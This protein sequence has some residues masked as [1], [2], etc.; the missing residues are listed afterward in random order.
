MHAEFNSKYIIETHALIRRFGTKNA[1]D[2]ID[3]QVPAQSVYGFIGPNGAGKTT[4]IRMLLGLIRPSS[5]GINILGYAVPRERIQVLNYV[6]A[7]VESPSLYPHLSGRENME[8]TRRLSNAT[9]T[10]VKRALNIV[11]LEE[12]AS[13]L[14]RTYSL[15][16]RQRLGIAL[17]LLRSPDLLILDEPTNGLDPAG[18]HEMRSLMR[19]MPAQHGITVF[20][21]SH[22]LTEVEQLATDVGIINHGKLVYQGKLD[23]LQA[24]YHPVMVLGV[25]Q[26]EEVLRYLNT[27][28][29]KAHSNGNSH[30]YVEVNGVSDVALINTQLVRS[31]W[32]VTHLALEQPNLENVFL[33]LTNQAV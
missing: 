30:L 19:E 2:G 6:G 11:G 21:S 13:R 3:L 25:E 17:A 23:Q 32:N 15:G 18:I 22:L 4:T 28:G 9:D 26:P 33:T 5:G 14:V 24:N 1:V 8:V 10:Q 16:M 27:S 31:G 12:D 29:W 7:L 20:L